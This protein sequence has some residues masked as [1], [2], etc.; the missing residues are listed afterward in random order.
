[1]QKC[2]PVAKAQFRRAF[3]RRGSNRSGSGNTAGSLFAPASDTVTRSPRRILASPRLTSAAA[4][5][6][7]TAAAGSSRSDSSTTLPTSCRSASTARSAA[8][9][10]S[11]NQT[12]LQI[13]P[14]VVSMPP[15]SSTAA[16][17]TT[18]PG[19]SAFAAAVS[20]DGRA[21]RVSVCSTHSPQLPER[22]LGG[23]DQ[24]RGIRSRCGGASMLRPPERGLVRDRAAAQPGLQAAGPPGPPSAGPPASAGPLAADRAETP[25][26]MASYQASNR[27]GATSSPSM[28]AIT[29]T[30]S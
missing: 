21:G 16:F 4:Y 17:D 5:R 11:K 2:G 26:T 30:A 19:V 25:A 13:M 7:T 18:S 10:R 9:S 12:A 6:S 22:R 23:R 24:Q 20:T 3:S 14:S 8:A 15:N 1:M 28:S 27:V 29:A